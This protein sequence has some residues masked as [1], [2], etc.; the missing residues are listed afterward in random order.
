M[1]TPTPPTVTVTHN[2]D[3]SLTTTVSSLNWQAIIKAILAA[4]LAA[5]GG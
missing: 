5:L 4:I 2:Q 1:P 3:G